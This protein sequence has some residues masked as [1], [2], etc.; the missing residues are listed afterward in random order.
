MNI[1]NLYSALRD[2]GQALI[3][4]SE[5]LHEAEQG[6]GRTFMPRLSRATDQAMLGHLD[7]AL[8]L[9][10]ELLAEARQGGS[11]VEEAFILSDL[12]DNLLHLGQH[13]EAREVALSAL[14][15][16]RSLGLHLEHGQMLRILGCLEAAEGR[17]EQ[18]RS[19]LEQALALGEQM[20][21]TQLQLAAHRD[22]SEVLET[23]VTWPER[24]GTPGP[25]TTSNAASCC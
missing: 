9:R 23:G 6:N 7:G 13:T 20:P 10:R 2:H 3:Y 19:F 21:S 25:I 18:A 16:T 1:G 5:A 24:C 8:A 15:L 22:L 17:P 12:A 11:A 4:H 14:G